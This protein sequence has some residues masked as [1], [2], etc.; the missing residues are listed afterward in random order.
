MSRYTTGQSRSV[1]NH[2]ENDNLDIE[3]NF[4]L[5]HHVAPFPTIIDSPTPWVLHAPTY[6]VYSSDI[7]IAPFHSPKVLTTAGT[8][9]GGLVGGTT[10]TSG[11]ALVTSGSGSGLSINVIW[12]SSVSSAPSGFTAGVLQVAQYFVDHL[13]DHVT[14]NINVGFGESGGYALNGALSM[15]LTSLQSSSYTQIKNALA[16]D[17]TSTADASGV[18][19]LVGD[20]TSGGNYWISTAESKA[21]G[22]LSSTTNSDGSVG[23][24][25]S[26]G[27]FDYDNSNGIGSGQYDFFSVVA[28]EFSEVMGRILLVGTTV[29]GTSNSFGVLDLFHYS[30]PAT[31][32]LSGSVAGYFSADNGTTDLHDFNTSALGGDRGDWASGLMPDAFDAFGT[33]GLVEPISASDLTALDAIGWNIASTPPPLGLPDLTASNLTVADAGTSVSFTL[34]NIGTANA[35]SPTASVYLS[36]D[37][38]ITTADQLLGTVSESSLAAGTSITISNLSI[39]LTAPT[40]AGT[41]YLGVVADPLGTIAE[42]SESNNVSNVLPLVLGTAGN[43]SLTGTSGRDLI[44]GFDGNGTITG[45]GGADTLIGGSG[46]DH[47]RYTAKTQGVDTIVDF[48]H[49]VDVFDFSRSAFGSHLAANGANTGVLDASHFALNSA[50]AATPQFIYDTTHH[51]LSFDA[52]GTGAIA[53][54]QIAELVNAPM[55]TNTDF[56]LI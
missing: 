30:A 56:H 44:I 28:H 5:S 47:F 12:D 35:I 33:A 18:A 55:L 41:Y 42:A 49:G 16:A 6:A 46:A 53:A 20:P 17:Q 23:F 4:I 32:D 43:N 14:L 40:T 25:S 52:D 39:A 48:T 24:S 38:A 3:T 1:I 26:L 37:A 34:S 51:I 54:V 27:I 15:S 31:H 8:G 9:A 2:A 10:T 11:S 13:T 21:M 22:L 45:G 29:G 36:S 19:S 7:T 50:T